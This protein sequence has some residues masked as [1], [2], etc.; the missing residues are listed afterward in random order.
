[1][2]QLS[3]IS[4]REPETAGLVTGT[5]RMALEDSFA[6]ELP[7]ALATVRLAASCLARPEIGDTVLTFRGENHEGFILAIL[8]RAAREP[9]TLGFDRGV[10]VTIGTGAFTVSAP[11]ILFEAERRVSVTGSELAVRAGCG[12]VEVETLSIRGKKLAAVWDRVST[13]FRSLEEV[14]ERAVQKID[15]YYR[16]VTEFEESRLGRLRMI[17]GGQLSMRSK[18]TSIS[19][20]ETMKIDGE[21]IHLG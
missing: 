21:T 2:E 19:A 16:T 3:I 13:A 20:E 4:R 7:D 17:V 11:E 12:D 18:Q 5:V 8:V 1:M 14:C 10:S 9:L 6:V 15:R